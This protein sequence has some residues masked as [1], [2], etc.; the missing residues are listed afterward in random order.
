MDLKSSL[1]K[2]YEG[3]D[4]LSLAKPG[5]VSTRGYSTKDSWAKSA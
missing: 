4:T 1:K 5:F 2:S 3:E